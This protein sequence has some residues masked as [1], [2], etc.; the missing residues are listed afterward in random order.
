MGGLLSQIPA[1]PMDR[2]E[3]PR[4]NSAHAR[5]HSH[6]V[7]HGGGPPPI[8]LAQRRKPSVCAA[9]ASAPRWPLLQLTRRTVGLEELEQI[10]ER[11][12]VPQRPYPYRAVMIVLVNPKSAKWKHRL[13]MS[14]L[15]LAA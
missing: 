14:I 5:L 8:G 6:C 12:G 13:P 10:K 3:T 2:P 9:L 11:L 15:S 7:R 4:T 1:A